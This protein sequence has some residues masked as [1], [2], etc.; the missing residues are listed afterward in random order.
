MTNE[1]RELLTMALLVAAL[2]ALAPMERDPFNA[3]KEW[4]RNTWDT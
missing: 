4:W 1:D 3:I 2:Y